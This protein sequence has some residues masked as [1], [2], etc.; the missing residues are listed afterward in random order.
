MQTSEDVIHPSYG[1]NSTCSFQENELLYSCSAEHQG[2][3]RICPC[4]GFRKYQIALCEECYWRPN[5]DT[6]RVNIWQRRS[7]TVPWAWY[8]RVPFLCQLNWTNVRRHIQ[9]RNNLQPPLVL[10]DS[11]KEQLKTIKITRVSESGPSSVGTY[12]QTTVIESV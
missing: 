5:A 2:Y 6:C 8:L 12:W 7:I 4:R 3:R 1:P 11:V 9:L 10:F